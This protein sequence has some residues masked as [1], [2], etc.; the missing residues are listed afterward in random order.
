MAQK[1]SPADN[2]WAP[3][4]SSLA[5]GETQWLDGC[6]AYAFLL[7]FSPPPPPPQKDVDF[8]VKVEDFTVAVVEDGDFMAAVVENEDSMAA[9]V[10]GEDFMLS[11]TP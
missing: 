6:Y 2:S 8:R 11:A 5:H 1:W 7:I 3:Y 4:K 9:V 10:K